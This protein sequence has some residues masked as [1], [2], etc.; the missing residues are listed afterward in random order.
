M[1]NQKITV[2]DTGSA[3]LTS[4]VIALRHLGAD[5]VISTD[6][7]TIREAN[8]LI[9][10]GVG[11][12]SAAMKLLKER[13]LPDLVKSLTQPVLGICLGMQ[14]LGLESQENMGE[15]GESVPVSCLGLVNGTVSLMKTGDLPLPHMGWDQVSC[16]R[17]SP[18][19]KD[20]PDN[21]YFYFVHSY[22]MNVC[23]D[24]LAVTEYGEKFTAVV[25]KDNFFG[26]QF[27][28]EKSGRIGARLLNNFLNL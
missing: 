6:E 21:S 4:V 9:L 16:V 10:P 27:H 2:I 3:N 19:F 20:I 11:T 28:P 25:Q 8:R 14:M 22:A 13:N 7:K 15:S 5:P 1:Q 17:E 18:L 24:T 23:A 12:A 26:T